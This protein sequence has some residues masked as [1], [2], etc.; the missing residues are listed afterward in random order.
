M[1]A[2]AIMAWAQ[3]RQTKVYR[4]FYTAVMLIITIMSGMLDM[5]RE[6]QML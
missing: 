6:R 4:F 2:S 3:Y 1:E 5:K